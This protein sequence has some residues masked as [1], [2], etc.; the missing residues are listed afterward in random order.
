L[1]P[2]AN[3]PY[4]KSI[5]KNNSYRREPFYPLHPRTWKLWLFQ[6]IHKKDFLRPD[7]SWLEFAEDQAI[8]YPMLEMAGENFVTI[9]KPIYVHNFEH[10][11]SDIK[12]NLLGLVK[13]EL[14]IRKKP[15]Y[16]PI[17]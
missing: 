10:K 2:Y 14:V 11:N 12:R 8:F 17:Y 13:D 3:L 9:K 16:E 4:S 7:G 5:K 1:V 15:R 6:K